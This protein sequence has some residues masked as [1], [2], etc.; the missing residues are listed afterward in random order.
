MER[1]EVKNSPFTL[2]KNENEEVFITCGNQ[3][4]SPEKFKTFEEAIKYIKKKPWELITT[5]MFIVINK[6]QEANK[7]NNKD[8]D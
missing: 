4:M 2:V 8:N 7:L 6:T 3:I 1:I 5:L